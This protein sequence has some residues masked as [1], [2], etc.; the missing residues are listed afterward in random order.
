[1]LRSTAETRGQSVSFHK[2]VDEADIQPLNSN[3]PGGTISVWMVAVP[4]D[5][6][7]LCPS[8]TQVALNLM[9]QWSNPWAGIQAAS[10]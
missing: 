7:G 9:A 5:S 4:A 10:V 8:V 2:S 1:M 6:A 3:R